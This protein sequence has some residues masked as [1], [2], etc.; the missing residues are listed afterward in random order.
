MTCIV[1]DPP[2]TVSFVNASTSVRKGDSIRLTCR[3]SIAFPAP[4]INWLLNGSPTVPQPQS[5]VRRAHGSYTESSITI[6]TNSLL[7]DIYQLPVD[8]TATNDEGSATKQQMIRILSPPMSPV[9]VQFG[10]NP[11]TEGDLLNLTCEAHGGNP[12][13]VLSWYRGVEKVGYF[14]RAHSI[15]AGYFAV[16]NNQSFKQVTK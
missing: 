16:F 7:S 15:F 1:L 14:F 4:I 9:I 8:C 10:G 3:S 2:S 12:M 11:M 6:D 13:A 5:E